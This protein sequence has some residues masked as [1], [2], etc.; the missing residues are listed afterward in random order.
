[1]SKNR[2]ILERAFRKTFND[3]D[4]WD[5]QLRDF[6]HGGYGWYSAIMLALGMALDY[7]K[8]PIEEL[9]EEIEKLKYNIER[10]FDAYVEDD[11]TEYK[12]FNR[13][14]KEIFESLDKIKELEDN[15]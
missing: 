5:I 1:M 12:E 4:D 13:R 6:E 11:A 2:E 8:F 10:I 14:K 9:Q 3:T 7:R 15:G